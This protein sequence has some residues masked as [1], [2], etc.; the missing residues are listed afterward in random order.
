MMAARPAGG[1]AVATRPT[2][3][4]LVVGGGAWILSTLLYFL[5]QGYVAAGWVHPTYSWSSNY[6]S[7]LG[8]TTCGL[9]KVPHGNDVLVCSPRH[10][11]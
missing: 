10:A 1:G 5:A 6:I 8:N 3:T 11:S 9:F 7:D 2:R 4:A